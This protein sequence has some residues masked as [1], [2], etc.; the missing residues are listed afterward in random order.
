MFISPRDAIDRGWIKFPQWMTPDQCNKCIQP[1]AIDFTVDRLFIINPND[2]A[3][4]SEDQRV[5][6]NTSELGDLLWTL[7]Q[8]KVYDGMSDFTV[9]VPEQVACMLINRSS[10]NRLGIHLNCGL[11][12]SGYT[13]SIGFTLHNRVGP[14]RMEPHTRVGQIIFIESKSV[15]LYAGGFNTQAGQHW[16]D[17][18]I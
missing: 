7:E 11:Y 13:G 6:H 14:V 10:I 1:N 16:T 18:G 4:I 2:N 8:N 3:F 12:D 9:T 15:G 17:K 5:W